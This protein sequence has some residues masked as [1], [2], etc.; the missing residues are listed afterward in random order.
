[1]AQVAR[2][3]PADK[4][5][6]DLSN[7]HFSQIVSG[8]Q[9]YVSLSK[10]N[11]IHTS[12]IL[13]IIAMAMPNSEEEVRK[14]YQDQVG[15]D[16][17]NGDS[18][19][20]ED[21]GG[22]LYERFVNTTVSPEYGP[23]PRSLALFSSELPEKRRISRRALWGS[24]IAVSLFFIYNTMFTT[25]REGPEGE[26]VSTVFQPSGDITYVIGVAVG[27][28]LLYVVF[29]RFFSKPIGD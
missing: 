29:L 13:V 12:L 2:S 7:I 16:V 6:K 28:F 10:T 22:Y 3:E 26:Q 20:S 23:K 1:M 4:R 11:Q 9:L 19:S 17:T 18:G 24:R 21:T 5:S 15:F 27:V 25:V 8:M 14:E